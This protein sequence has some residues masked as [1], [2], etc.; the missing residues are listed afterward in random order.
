M[1]NDSPVIIV[2]ADQSF[3]LLYSLAF[4]LFQQVVICFESEHLLLQL[5]DFSIIMTLSHF[6]QILDLLILCL[7]FIQFFLQFFK[8]FFTL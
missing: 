1:A 4:F 6:E 5:F 7:F 3:L 8:Q 2:L